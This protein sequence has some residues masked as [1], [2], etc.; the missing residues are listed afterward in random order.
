VVAVVSQPL[1]EGIAFSRA[2]G[3][4]SSNDFRP[5]EADDELARIR[6]FEHR[7]ANPGI[8][9]ILL[10]E[11]SSSGRKSQTMGEWTL[12]SLCSVTCPSFMVT[13]WRTRGG[14]ADNRGAWGD[15]SFIGCFCVGS[16]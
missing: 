9:G 14:A 13:W 1:P 2:P 16:V 6:G 3:H 7:E 8:T 12:L 4:P 15:G 5:M 10:M 11:R